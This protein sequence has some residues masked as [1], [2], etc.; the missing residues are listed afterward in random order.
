MQPERVHA[1]VPEV[2][3]P[4]PAQH[5]WDPVP[6]FPPCPGLPLAGSTG[7]WLGFSASFMSVFPLTLPLM[8]SVLSVLF[9]ELC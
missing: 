5:S 3:L 8:A 1:V 4:D 2:S 7:Q 6:L 9:P